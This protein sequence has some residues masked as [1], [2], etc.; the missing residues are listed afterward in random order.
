MG[1]GPAIRTPS[2]AANDRHGRRAS[3][4]ALVDA[5]KDRLAAVF[6]FDGARA[7]INAVS[8]STAS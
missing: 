5:Q 1:Q 6:S 2:A 3:P 8:T 4:L 7:G